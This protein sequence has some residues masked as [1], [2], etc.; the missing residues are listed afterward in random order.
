MGKLLQDSS[1]NSDNLLPSQ[2][3]IDTNASKIQALF[4]GVKFREKE[5]PDI[6]EQ[7]KN[8]HQ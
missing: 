3:D 5:L 4:R 7:N 1:A 8:W 6:N 2:P